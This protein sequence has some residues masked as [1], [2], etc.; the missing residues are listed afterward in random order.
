MGRHA[1]RFDRSIASFQRTFRECERKSLRQ[2]IVSSCVLL[3]QGALAQAG[4]RTRGSLSVRS[5]T[6][7]PPLS[8]ALFKC[9]LLTIKVVQATGENL[10]MTEY[11][12]EYC[13]HLCEPQGKFSLTLH[14]YTL[15]KKKVEKKIT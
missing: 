7:L 1:E 3:C 10:N 15:K 5:E 9:F 2:H 14:A 13:Y 6:L 4:S 11:E 8:G 12:S